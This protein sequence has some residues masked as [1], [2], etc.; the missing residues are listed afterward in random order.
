MDGLR[1]VGRNDGEYFMTE[2]AVIAG[3]GNLPGLVLAELGNAKVICFEGESEP[4]VAADLLT[5]FG[6]IGQ[7]LEFLRGNNIKKIVFA[8]AMQRPDIKNLSPDAEGA[9]LLAKILAGSLFGKGLGDD[10]LLSVITKFLED[11]GFEVVGVQEVLKNI[12]AGKGVMGKVQPD[13]LQEEDIKTGMAVFEKI[14][15]V[16]IG[17]SLV[18]EDGVV[19]AVEAVEGTAAMI[20]RSGLLKKSYGGVLVKFK[21]PG[22]NDKVDMPSIGADTVAQAAAAGV[23]GIAI[24]AG[25]VLMIEKARIIEAADAAGVFVV[26]V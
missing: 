12:L 21:K 15:G 23:R 8:G 3:K 25:E 9:K 10:K 5:R 7:I 17:Q 6:R 26:G 20:A 18:V 2:Y 22:Q 4:E 1:L 13:A 14:G 19:I 16:D 24:E 11:K